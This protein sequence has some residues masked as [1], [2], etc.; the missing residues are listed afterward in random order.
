MWMGGSEGGAALALPHSL[1]LVAYYPEP[2]ARL[3]E[4]LQRLPEA[5]QKVV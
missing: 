1:A 3:I 4:A 5:H 2:V